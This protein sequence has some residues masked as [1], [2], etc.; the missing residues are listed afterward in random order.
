MYT[1]EP[2]K[3]LNEFQEIDTTKAFEIYSYTD[4]TV[5][6]NYLDKQVNKTILILR[7]W[8][9]LQNPKQDSKRLLEAIKAQDSKNKVPSSP[10]ITI[11]FL[12]KTLGIRIQN[13]RNDIQHLLRTSYEQNQLQIHNETLQ[14]RQLSHPPFHHLQKKN[15][16]CP[17]SPQFLRNR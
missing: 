10:P 5:I 4:F 7:G 14:L 8:I 11:I 17:L 12:T 13:Q 15:R 6:K 16:P 1:S 3:H 2:I 9:E